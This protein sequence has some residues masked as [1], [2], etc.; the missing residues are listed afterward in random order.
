MAVKDVGVSA[1]KKRESVIGVEPRVC[2]V[3]KDIEEMGVMVLWVL[4]GIISVC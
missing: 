2:A 4:F 1:I 3:D